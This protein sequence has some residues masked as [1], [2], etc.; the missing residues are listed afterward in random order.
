MIIVNTDNMRIVGGM[1]T[2][3]ISSDADD[4]PVKV[5]FE[6]NIITIGNTD[7]TKENLRDIIKCLKEI[8][9]AL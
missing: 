1:N 9:Y 7:Y 6:E 2:K 4:I 5:D 3:S 8:G